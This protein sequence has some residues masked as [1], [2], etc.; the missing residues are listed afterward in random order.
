MDFEKLAAQAMKMQQEL[1]RVQEEAASEPSPRAP[2]A[3]R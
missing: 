3:A 2:A 1:Q